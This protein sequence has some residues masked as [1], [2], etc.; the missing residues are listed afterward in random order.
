[1]CNYEKFFQKLDF[2]FE[3]LILNFTLFGGFLEIN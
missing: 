1:M 3:E 2:N